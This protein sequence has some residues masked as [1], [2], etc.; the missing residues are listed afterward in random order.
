MRSLVLF[1]KKSVYKMCPFSLIEL[2][3]PEMQS[4]CLSHK[5]MALRNAFMPLIS[6]SAQTMMVVYTTVTPCCV[7]YIQGKKT[8]RGDLT[9]APTSPK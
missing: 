7:Y 2:E 4:I 6:H 3:L 5:F 1:S 9:K 8:A